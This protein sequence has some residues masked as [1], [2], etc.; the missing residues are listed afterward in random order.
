MRPSWEF[1][2]RGAGR[3]GRGLEQAGERAGGH[4]GPDVASV[5]GVLEQMRVSVECDRD[6]RVAEDAAD[7]GYVELALTAATPAC[8]RGSESEVR[9]RASVLEDAGALLRR[10]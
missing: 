10:Q 7:L 6:A 4:A 9:Q 2:D 5:A 1:E 3:A 8:T